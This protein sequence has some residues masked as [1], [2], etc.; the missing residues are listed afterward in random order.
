MVATFCK[1]SKMPA[2]M[3]AAISS[4]RKIL[5]NHTTPLLAMNTSMQKNLWHKD[6]GYINRKT[7][8]KPALLIGNPYQSYLWSKPVIYTEGHPRTKKWEFEDFIGSLS[9]R[10]SR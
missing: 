5:L 6:I 9:W 2:S 1:G 3:N 10:E 4:N 8:R 7:K